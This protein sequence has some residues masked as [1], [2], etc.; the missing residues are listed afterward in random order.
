MNRRQFLISAGGIALSGVT[1]GAYAKLIEPQWLRVSRIA[2]PLERLK[3]SI[4][5]LHLSDLHASSEKQLSLVEKAISLGLN[6][7]PDIVLI[8][9]DFLTA[10]DELNPALG[11]VLRRL[12]SQIPTF[13]CLGNHDG[14][15]WAET[16]GGHNNPSA[17]KSLLANHGVRILENQTLTLNLKGQTIA[18]SGVG[19]AW[20]GRC[21]PTSLQRNSP[22]CLNLLMCHN[23]DSKSLVQSYSWDIMFSGHTHGG[24]V[25]VPFVGL[26]PF[27]PVVDR[28]FVEGLYKW[29]G[30]YIHITR[31]VGS[32]YGIRFNCRPEISIMDL[33]PSGF[34]DPVRTP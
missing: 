14:G 3:T 19:D 4:R 5:V 17:L 28:R 31:G 1:G 2:V 12:S 6:A 20:A 24:Q 13:A 9:G 22:D 33:I 27:L 11:A 15:K 29:E 34:A 23:P 16:R 8:T 10:G 21:D 30:R 26:R 18:L 25:V 32:L 7:V